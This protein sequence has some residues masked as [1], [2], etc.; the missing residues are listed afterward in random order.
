MFF[1]EY[2]F[3]K[4]LTASFN[5]RT[6]NSGITCCLSLVQEP[7]KNI[8]AVYDAK[9]SERTDRN[10]YVRF[11][12]GQFNMD[13]ALRSSWKSYFHEDRLNAL[14][15]VDIHQTTWELFIQMNCSHTTIDRHLNHEDEEETWCVGSPHAQWEQPSACPYSLVIALTANNINPFLSRIDT[16][17]ETWCL[18]INVTHRKQ[19]PSPSLVCKLNCIH[20]SGGTKKE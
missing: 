5:W 11:K 10:W 17:D 7:V 20:A 6:N 13:D 8:C 15:H 12:K 14:V 16:H 4:S 3:V 18:Y 19:R 1:I 9:I 2:I